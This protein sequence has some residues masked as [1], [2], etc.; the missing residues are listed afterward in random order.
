MAYHQVFDKAEAPGMIFAEIVPTYKREIEGETCIAL[1]FQPAA[2][3][4]HINLGRLLPT[5]PSGG[6]A[7][8]QARYLWLAR[9][10]HQ[11]F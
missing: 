1:A 2:K 4:P 11:L 6:S 5:I 9:H 8:I 3:N 7:R 10:R